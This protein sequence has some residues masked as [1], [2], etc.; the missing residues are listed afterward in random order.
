MKPRRSAASEQKKVDKWTYPIGQLV[1]VKKDD[2]TTLRTR[3]RSAAQLLSGHTAVIWVDGIAGC[4]SLDCVK[5][6]ID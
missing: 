5:P 2:G 6:V 1:D 4:Y 3:T